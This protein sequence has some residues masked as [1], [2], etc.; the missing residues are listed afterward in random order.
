MKVHSG[1]I[2]LLALGAVVDSHVELRHA[3]MEVKSHKKALME[4]V[5]FSKI[6]PAALEELL[7]S[8]VIPNLH[9]I[10]SS[11]PG[12]LMKNRFSQLL[13]VHELGKFQR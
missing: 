13:P 3:N 1:F 9:F 4:I 10:G 12:V 8:A 11:S 2:F 5:I 6:R 7:S